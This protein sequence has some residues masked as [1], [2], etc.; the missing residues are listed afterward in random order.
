MTQLLPLS[1]VSTWHCAAR[2]LN[3][4][5]YANYANRTGIKNICGKSEQSAK[6][7]QSRSWLKSPSSRLAAATKATFCFLVNL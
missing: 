6:G 4:T 2:R 5:G 7:V 1:S 3:L